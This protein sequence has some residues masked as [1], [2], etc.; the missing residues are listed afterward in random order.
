MDEI[1]E[2]RPG[3]TG[4][5]D[6]VCVHGR[7]VQ[8]QDDNLRRLMKRAKQCG[9]VFNSEKCDIRKDEIFFVNIYSKDRIHP[10]PAKIKGIQSMSIL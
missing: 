1:L 9:L 6:D 3:V 5:T 10:G 8:E 7:D 4:I 2:D